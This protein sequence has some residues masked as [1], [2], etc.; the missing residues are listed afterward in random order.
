MKGNGW[1]LRKVYALGLGILV[2]AG[3][4]LL[5]SSTY[6][7]AAEEQNPHWIQGVHYFEIDGQG[8]FAVA[9]E[10]SMAAEGEP[11]KRFVD[12]NG[13]S[14]L[15]IRIFGMSGR[16]YV[17]GLGET[18]YWLDKSRP[19]GRSMIREKVRGTAFPAVHEMH[20]HLLLT[21]EALPGRT[22]RSINPAVMVNSNATSFPPQ[23]GAQ[24]E[25]KQVVELED[26]DDPGPVVIR[27]LSNRNQIVGVGRFGRGL[28]G[29]PHEG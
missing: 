19:V 13:L 24:Y 5:L 14:T 8:S 4:A 12:R 26:V 1:K 16:G 7:S 22:F 15:P 23:V 29:R 3:A 28:N 18:M 11:T 27:I 21:T 9:S 10:E 20:F 17:E 2:V 6:S 25:L